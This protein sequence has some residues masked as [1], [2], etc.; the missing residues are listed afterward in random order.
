MTGA[1]ANVKDNTTAS[2]VVEKRRI[3]MIVAF[4]G[5]THLNYRQAGKTNNA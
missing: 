4:Y 5:R 3:D 2:T 1:V